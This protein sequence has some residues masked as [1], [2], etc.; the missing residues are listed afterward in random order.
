MSLAIIGVLATLLLVLALN[1]SRFRA[2]G[3]ERVARM[4]L[5]WFGI[6]AGLGVALRLLGY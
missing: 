2:M 5:I 3:W 6:I 4:L 1:W